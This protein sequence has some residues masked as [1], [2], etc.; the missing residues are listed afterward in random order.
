MRY[1]PKVA[2]AVAIALSQIGEFSF[3][4]AA[5]GKNLG[6]LPAAAGNALVATAILSISLN[7]LLYAAVGP[8]DAWA[9]RHSRLWRWFAARARPLTSNSS[10]PSSAHDNVDSA[11][12]RAVIVGYGP[13]GRTLSRLLRDNEIEPTI[14][15]MNLETVHRL[16]E[17]GIKVVYG[18]A[19]HFETLKSAGVDL[20][21][22]LILSASGIRNA[23]EVIRLTREL[24]PRIQTLARTAYLSEKAGLLKAGADLVFTE[25]GE[26]ALAMAE[27][28]LRGRG[29]ITEQFDRERERVRAELF[30][31]PESTGGFESSQ[32]QVPADSK[33]LLRTRAR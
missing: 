13:V 7:P 25:E 23:A 17:D 10:A 22:S 5:L 8:L 12:R 15:E 26:I 2:V 21:G 6:L 32:F 9:M 24:N 27:Y 18:D 11:G 29:A 31:A 28:V 14:I 16:R 4:V 33:E 3:I 19:S 30:G 20:A 1:P